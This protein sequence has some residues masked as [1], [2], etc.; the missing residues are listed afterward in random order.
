MSFRTRFLTPNVGTADRWL[1]TL[2]FVLFIYVWTSGGPGGA[3]LVAFG[4]IATML[5]VTAVT[6]LRSIY[7]MFGFSTRRDG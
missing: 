3:A 7:A 1:R 5:F 2:P 4:I 6:G